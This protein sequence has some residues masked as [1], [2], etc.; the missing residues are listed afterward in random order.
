MS[1]RFVIQP[2]RR[3]VI[4]CAP[5][6]AARLG[7]ILEHT[8]QTEVHDLGRVRVGKEN[9]A[10]FDVAMDEPFFRRGLESLRDL[11]ADLK[12]LHFGYAVLHGHQVVERSFLDEFHGQVELPVRLAERIDPNDMRVVDRRGDAGFL[13]E[14]GPLVLARA[15]FAAQ[16]LKRD[17][18]AEIVIVGFE[19]GPH[20]A[21][22]DQLDQFEI[23][24]DA[25]RAQA[26]AAVRTINLR[27]GQ[28]LGHVDGSAA[29]GTRVDDPGGRFLVH[30]ANLARDRGNV[31]RFRSLP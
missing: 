23:I 5:D 31:Q 19:D 13:L 25:A 15:H 30:A 17:H 28:F 10:R 9:V 11:H 2:L 8:G 27:E 21:L 7:L 24:E 16:D 29:G 20:P 3:D 22:A 1:L 4:R 18:A 14:L 6:L 12:D 26:L